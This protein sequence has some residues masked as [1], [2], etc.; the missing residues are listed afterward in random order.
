LPTTPDTEEM[1]TMRPQ[2][3]RIIGRKHARV[4]WKK[5]SR[6]VRVTSV[7]AASVIPARGPS[8]EMPALLTRIANGFASRSRAAIAFATA[9]PSRTSKPTA[10]AL[11][12]ASTMPATTASAASALLR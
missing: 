9:S 3:S 8:F 10:S 12:P 1:F 6:V 4:T 7:Q 5:P 2:R 11:P